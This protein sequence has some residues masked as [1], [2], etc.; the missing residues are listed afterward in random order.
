MKYLLFII[1]VLL[2]LFSSCKKENLEDEFYE[3]H[4]YSKP[5]Y[6]AKPAGRYLIYIYDSVPEL[7]NQSINSGKTAEF[8]YDNK[9][10]V[11]QIIIYINSGETISRNIRIE[12]NIDGQVTKIKYYNS[13]DILLSFES[14]AYD[15]AG[16]LSSSE[17]N[18][19]DVSNATIEA[20][21]LDEFI[22]YGNDSII[23][24]RNGK[25][26]YGAFKD[27]HILDDNKNVI[28]IYYYDNKNSIYPTT[29]VEYSYDNNSKIIENLNLPIYNNHLDVGYYRIFNIG[30]VFSTNNQTSSQSYSYENDGSAT[31]F[32]ELHTNEYVYDELGYPVSKNNRTYYYYTD[33]E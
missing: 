10:Y 32:G 20:I 11:E 24:L 27:L 31:P 28:H 14:F 30:E 4:N 2:I 15:N 21:T 26:F 16:R 5:N 18:N 22:Y 19:V 17:L 33:L 13:D 12:Y 29:S 7:P 9:N 6:P 23:R 25:Y 3:L 1:G 8:I